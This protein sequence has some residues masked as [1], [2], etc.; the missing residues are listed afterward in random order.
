MTKLGLAICKSIAKAHGGSLSVFN[1]SNNGATFK[2][3]LAVEREKNG[4]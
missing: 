2:L 1:N 4:Y 3:E